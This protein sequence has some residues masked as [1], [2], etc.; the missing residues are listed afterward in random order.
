MADL[1]H[2]GESFA[3]HIPAMPGTQGFCQW[4]VLLT[5]HFNPIAFLINVLQLQAPVY[6]FFLSK[7]ENIKDLWTFFHLWSFQSLSGLGSG[8]SLL[9]YSLWCRSDLWYVATACIIFTGLANKWWSLPSSILY[10]PFPV[11][12]GFPSLLMERIN[13]WSHLL[14]LLSFLN[15]SGKKPNT[16]PT[17]TTIFNC[18]GPRQ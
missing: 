15:Q 4:A 18:N 8:F 17:T 2:M 1:C 13:D 12:L 14:L 5:D 11:T 3:H 7:R 9:F 10:L 16:P 6:F